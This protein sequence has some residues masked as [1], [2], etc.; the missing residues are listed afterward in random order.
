M[1]S[2]PMARKPGTQRLNSYRRNKARGLNFVVC[3]QPMMRSGLLRSW[4]RLFLVGRSADGSIDGYPLEIIDRYFDD[5]PKMSKQK[6][7]ETCQVFGLLIDHTVALL[8]TLTTAQ[9]DRDSLPLERV[10]FRSFAVALA[11]G[12]ISFR[13]GVPIDQKGLFWRPRSARRAFRLLSVLDDFFNHLKS[14]GVTPKWLEQYKGV[15]S[16]AEAFR[17]SAHLAIRRSKSMLEHINE[18]LGGEPPHP[19]SS[20]VGSPGKPTPKTFSFPAKW[21]PAFLLEGFTN[22]QGETDDTAQLIAFFLFYGGLRTSESFHLFCSDVQFVG[23]HPAIYLHH[24]E[25]GLLEFNKQ[26]ITRKEYLLHFKRTARTMD[27]WRDEA[28]W[29]SVRNDEEGDPIYWLPVITLPEMLSKLLKR[30]LR[31]TRPALMKR[32]PARLGDHPFLF[33]SSGRTATVSGGDVG[34]PYTRSA[35]LSAWKAAV[36]RIARRYPESG[37][38]YGKRHGTSPHGARHFYG[39]FLRTLGVAGEIIQICMHHKHPDSHLRYVELSP[40]EVNAILKSAAASDNDQDAAT[41]N[42]L[43]AARKEFEEAFH[44][45]AADRRPPHTWNSRAKP[46]SRRR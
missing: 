5:H 26:L 25:D 34:E 17:V 21:V 36:K 10:V 7:K 42:P 8:P 35:F 12:S 23:S 2:Q 19:F 27:D 46:W 22:D 38:V 32:R 31:V 1:A 9:L 18:I 29:K 4:H 14:M 28:G 41:Q 11:Y 15:M 45:G 37:L 16:A 3:R 33:V 43:A 39:R 6:R 20:V 30:Y 13:D 40:D 24:P 44:K